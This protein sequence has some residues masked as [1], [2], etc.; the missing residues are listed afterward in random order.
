MAGAN[1]LQDV[2]ENKS[3]LRDA[4]KKRAVQAL[5]PKNLINRAG[6]K[7]K[8][9]NPAKRATKKVGANR[10]KS[11]GKKGKRKRSKLSDVPSL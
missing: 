8:A 10:G 4:V 1:A 9:V 5:H 7:R 6:V 11:G 3:N 2:S